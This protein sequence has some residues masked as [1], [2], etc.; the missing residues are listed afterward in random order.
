[1]DRTMDPVCSVRTVD[2]K[3]RAL[4]VLALVAALLGAT[5]CVPVP[6]PPP[7]LCPPPQV[8]LFPNCTGPG[9]SPSLAPAD[10]R[11]VLAES[12][13]VLE[14]GGYRGVS[15]YIEHSPRFAGPV[16]LRSVV[17]EGVTA[18]VW[19]EMLPVPINKGEVWVG[20]DERAKP[21]VRTVTL[22]AQ[23]IVDGK[24]VERTATLAV[25]VSHPYR[26][27]ANGYA[28]VEAGGAVHSFGM[29]FRGRSTGAPRA[30]GV[31]IL[32]GDPDGYWILTEDGNV[33]P[34]GDAQALG[35][36]KGSRLRAPVVD[37][38]ATPSG[39]GY[40]I[41]AADGGVFSFGDAQFHGSTGAMKLNQPVVAMA[42]TRSGDGYWLVA[43][44]GGIFTFGAARFH[45][46]TG[47][48]RLNAPVV[49]IAPATTGYWLLAADGGVFAF[50]PSTPFHGA[51][52][53]QVEG[54]AV[55]IV[56]TNTA[57]GYWVADGH[58]NVFAF[59]AATWLGDLRGRKIS[60]VTGF[61]AHRR[62][63]G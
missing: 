10:F 12:E 4:P 16:T 35:S 22:T 29:P 50:G 46:S 5:G 1:M 38:R 36:L 11:L 9:Q 47:N 18:S 52:V 54:G 31:A 32:P 51:A 24:N 61:D 57:T 28:L 8:G 7:D 40:W 62:P 3:R 59:G 21:G 48:R 58:G 41:L 34:F 53:G 42:A 13:V 19:P 63:N 26:L 20:V 39:N 30:V 43:R 55:A 23:G 6:F 44:D 33:S 37:I 56:V 27:H 45:G 14:P 60:V 2:R 17:E 15:L 25:R 49:D